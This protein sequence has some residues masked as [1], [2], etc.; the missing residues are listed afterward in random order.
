[1]CSDTQEVGGQGDL[2]GGMLQ[3]CYSGVTVKSQ[4]GYSGVTVCSDTQE[5]G[6]QGDLC[7]C[8]CMCVCVCVYVCLC[9]CECMCVCVCVSMCVCVC[10]CD[11]GSG[12]PVGQRWWESRHAGGRAVALRADR[13][14]SSRHQTPQGSQWAPGLGAYT[15]TV[16]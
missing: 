4:H 14:T 3:W 7:A 9:V 11:C 15:Y 12:A 16:L 1:V 8:V 2:P 13:N 5:V 6:G 10:V